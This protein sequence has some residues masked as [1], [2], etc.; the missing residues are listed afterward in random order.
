MGKGTGIHG[1]A[2]PVSSLNYLEYLMHCKCYVNNLPWI[3]QGITRRKNKAVCVQCRD[4]IFQY[5]QLLE[6][7]D[8]EPDMKGRLYC[9][10]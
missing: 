3:V 1:A 8:V 4:N 2:F 7:I 5:L 10:L 6:S 9:L